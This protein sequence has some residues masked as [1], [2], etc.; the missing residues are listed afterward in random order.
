MRGSWNR[1][2]PTGYEV[3]RVHF[4]GGAP[5]PLTPGGAAYDDFLSGFLI[6]G[7]AAHFGR[8][9]GLTVDPSGS[10]FVSE[11]TN[12]VI[13][14]VSYGP[15]GADAGVAPSDAAAA[16]ADATADSPAGQ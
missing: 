6:E 8:L 14:K 5:T 4:A 15:A 9:A 13:Y 16:A 10:L 7:G 3:V 12:G 11:D 2:V 1:S